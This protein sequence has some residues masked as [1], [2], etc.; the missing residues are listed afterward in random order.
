MKL[1]IVDHAGSFAEDKDVARR[2]RVEKIEPALNGRKKVVL[3]FSGIELT[4]QSFI[5]ALIS[6]LIRR[7]GAGV[8]ESITFKGCNASLRSLIT[9][10]SEY[11]QD[12]FEDAG[13]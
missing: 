11:S 1:R 5:H 13:N 12:T 8:L 10:V 4:T 7:R 3:D 6:D 9:V 2:L